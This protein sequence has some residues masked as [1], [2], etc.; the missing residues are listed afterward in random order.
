MEPPAAATPGG[1]ASP[2]QTM[3]SSEELDDAALLG[4]PPGHSGSGWLEGGGPSAPRTASLVTHGGMQPRG[5]GERPDSDE[6]T[7]PPDAGNDGRHS[8]LR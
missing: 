7:L 2:A 5:G 8:G 1:G 6:R 4:P 3:P